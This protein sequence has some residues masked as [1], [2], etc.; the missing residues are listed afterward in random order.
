MGENQRSSGAGAFFVLLLVVGFI[1]M[2]WWIFAIIIG[3]LLLAGAIWYAASRLDAR[4]AARRAIAARAD[5]QHA[6][7][8]AG[9]DRGLYG[10]YPPA[11][12]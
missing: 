9:D 7:I 10:A 11:V 12:A 4:D 5:E 2:F 6:Q 8:L 1:V 3:V